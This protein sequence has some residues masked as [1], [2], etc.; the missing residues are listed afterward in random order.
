MRQLIYQVCCTR[1]QVLFYLR[2]LVAVLKHFKIPKYDQFVD[3]KV[4]LQDNTIL[5]CNSEVPGFTDK[6]HRHI[7]TGKEKLIIFHEKK[8]SLP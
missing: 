2:G 6:D 4:F 1:Y 7:V 3:I 5:P 8:L